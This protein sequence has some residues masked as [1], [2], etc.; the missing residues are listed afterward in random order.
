MVM[1]SEKLRLVLGFDD[2]GNAGFCLY[3]LV[4]GTLCRCENYAVALNPY[5]YHIVMSNVSCILISCLYYK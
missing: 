5:W 3:M 2:V 1:V 4:D